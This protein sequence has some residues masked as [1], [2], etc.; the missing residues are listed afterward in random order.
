[1]LTGIVEA[2]ETL[3]R[4][5]AKDSRKLVG[6][7]PRKRGGKTK[8]TG[9]SPDDYDIVLI[10][11]DCSRATSGRILHDFEGHSFERALDPIVD[12]DAVLVTD[13][14]Q[15]SVGFARPRGI[16]HVTVVARAG[17]RVVAGF[18]IRNV[19]AYASRLKHWMRPFQ[20]V[21]SKYLAS[22]LGW[23]RMIERD[24]NRLTPRHVIALAAAG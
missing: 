13:G 11:R 5:S 4:K 10:A 9:T 16:E 19:N 2:D 7:S 14:R 22:Y 15:T 23:R 24:G 3:I 20:G 12:R 17:E 8:K 18:H 21:A 1:M 6:R